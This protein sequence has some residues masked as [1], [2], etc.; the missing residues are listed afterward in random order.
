VHLGQHVYDLKNPVAG[1]ETPPY[2]FEYNAWMMTV[3]A[4]FGSGQK[5]LTTPGGYLLWSMAWPAA[6][7]NGNISDALNSYL[8]NEAALSR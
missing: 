5:F 8:A 4:S 1:E 3:S 2:I 6:D 7:R